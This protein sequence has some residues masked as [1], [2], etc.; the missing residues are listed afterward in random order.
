M[1]PPNEIN[2]IDEHGGFT[3]I[4]KAPTSIKIVLDPIVG[5]REAIPGDYSP[6][7]NKPFVRW[8]RV[9]REH[10]TLWRP[11]ELL[12]G[13]TL[14]TLQEY[15]ERSFFQLNDNVTKAIYK[16]KGYSNRIVVWFDNQTGKRIA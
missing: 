8:E 9:V 10:D 12:K 13:E 15:D 11:S 14:G 7:L 5:E 6:T 3:A 16:V 1:L 4:T 2:V